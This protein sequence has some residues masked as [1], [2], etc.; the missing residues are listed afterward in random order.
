MF[1]I[2]Q[3]V[4]VRT[5]V[6]IAAEYGGRRGVVQEVG[7]L[8]DDDPEVNGAI[9]YAVRIGNDTQRWFN[10]YELEAVNGPNT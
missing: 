8:E 9:T 10:D 7:I 1:S 4:R 6:S 3:K 2:G 5:D